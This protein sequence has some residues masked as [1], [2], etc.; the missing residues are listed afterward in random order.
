MYILDEKKLFDEVL[1]LI[2]KTST[3]LCEDVQAALEV[4]RN[5]EVKGSVAETTLN[6]ILENVELAR[7]NSTPI[8]QD[9]GANIYY[10]SIPCGISMNRVE[11]VICCAT[12]EATNKSYLRPNAVDSVTGKNSGDNTGVLAPQIYFEEWDE[13]AIKIKLMLKGGGSENV[14]CQYTLPDSNIAAGRNLEGVY[15]CI[16][17][18]VNK[19]QGLGCASGIIGVGIGGD[20]ATGMKWAKKQLFRRVDD[21]NPLPELAELE[22]RL[23]NDLNELGIGPMGFGGKS[24]V[25]GVKIGALHRLPAS[26]F[27]S[28]AYMCWANRR[29]EVVIELENE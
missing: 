25:L 16:I 6:E 21:V 23:Y 12:V 22:S 17:D 3:D 15:K 8:C 27:V 26:F 19:A 28:I 10:I 24:T 11:E 14:S 13:P 20:R 4:A 18:A 1:E 2:R 29:R 7:Q 5:N 9:T